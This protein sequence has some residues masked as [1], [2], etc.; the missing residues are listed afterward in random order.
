MYLLIVVEMI[1]YISRI[2]LMVARRR[3]VGMDNIFQ[4]QRVAKEVY[5]S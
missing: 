3:P 2:V 1:H 4:S 5:I